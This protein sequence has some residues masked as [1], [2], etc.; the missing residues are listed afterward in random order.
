MKQKLCLL[1][2][3]AGLLAGAA[4]A[5]TVSAQD[6]PGQSLIA[7][8]AIDQWAIFGKGESHRMMQDQTVPGGYALVVKTAAAGQNTWDIQAG[9]P[10]AQPIHSGDAVLLAFWARTLAPPAGHPTANIVA[11]IQQS[12]A[13]YTRV[14]EQSLAIGMTWKLYYVSGTSTMD[15][16]PGEAAATLQ[17]ATDAQEIALGPVFVRDFGPGYDPAKLPVN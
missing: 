15:L 7:S 4:F 1:V 12:H 10:T 14:G 11:N 16:Q 2:T 17:L 13:P 3:I 8:P 9:V 5:T 6:L